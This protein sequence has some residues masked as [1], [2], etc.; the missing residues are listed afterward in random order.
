MRLFGELLGAGT[1]IVAASVDNVL[2]Q[3][4]KERKVVTN[5]GND[6]IQKI[7]E[8]IKMAAPYFGIEQAQLLGSKNTQEYR[9]MAAAYGQEAGEYIVSFYNCIRSYTSEDR[10][11]LLSLYE[12]NHIEPSGV[13]KGWIPE[14]GNPYLVA[15]RKIG[16]IDFHAFLDKNYE[17]NEFVKKVY[18]STSAYEGCSCSGR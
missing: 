12:H 5:T 6:K 9:E 11:G 15:D 17:G 1:K 16:M 4:D 8:K 14:E 2:D 3:K 10:I 7:E 18:Y 13:L